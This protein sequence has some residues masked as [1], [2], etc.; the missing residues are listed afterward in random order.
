MSN[1]FFLP[2]E[3]FTSITVRTD[4]SFKDPENPTPEEMVRVLT[5]GSCYSI[6]SKDHP[7]FAAL[8]EK[9]GSEGFIRIERGW[10]NGDT[11]IAPF[12]LNGYDFLPGDRFV[13]ACAMSGYLKYDHKW[14]R[15][16]SKQAATRTKS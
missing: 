13:S 16:H 6:S 3:C 14:R 10:W 11:V 7:D 12:F 8:R 15:E 5:V 1:E 4:H 9:L 2:E